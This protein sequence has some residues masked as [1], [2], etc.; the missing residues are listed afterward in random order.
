MQDSPI[1][2]GTQFTITR[3]HFKAVYRVQPDKGECVLA[4]MNFDSRERIS[5]LTLRSTEEDPPVISLSQMPWNSRTIHVRFNSRDKL[6]GTHWEDMKMVKKSSQE[7]LDKAMKLKLGRVKYEW[8][9]YLPGREKSTQLFWAVKATGGM[10][11]CGIGHRSY[12]LF[13]PETCDILAEF[14]SDGGSFTGGVLELKGSWQQKFGSFGVKVLTTF[15]AV[16]ETGRRRAHHIVYRPSGAKMA[17]VL[18]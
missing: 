5:A 15:L 4:E 10:Q 1:G 3:D 2:F 8:L 11:L 6:Q 16:Y 9:T 14:I 12:R 7:D 17:N 13:D 18:L